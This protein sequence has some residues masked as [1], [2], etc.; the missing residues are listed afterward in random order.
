M[1]EKHVCRYCRM[2]MWLTACAVVCTT[3]MEVMLRMAQTRQCALHMI[4]ATLHSECKQLCVQG[5]RIRHTRPVPSASVA[6][7]PAACM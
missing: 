7:R 2:V 5:E 1:G 6:P 4:I 3:T